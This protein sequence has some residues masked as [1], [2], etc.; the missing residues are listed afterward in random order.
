[1]PPLC[2]S[3]NS[4]DL[5][6][7]C[8]LQESHE[9]A[10]SGT[11]ELLGVKSAVIVGIGSLEALLDKRDKFIF[12][13]SPVFVGVGRGEILGI[14]PTAQFTSVE[15]AIMIPV[16][17]IEQLPGC[18]LRFSEIDCAVVIRIERF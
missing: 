14:E 3:Q 10:A 7:E 1:M 18:S 12:V 4:D 13:Q 15:G 6:T 2:C 11:L 16:E 17:L 8:L 5:T 9:G